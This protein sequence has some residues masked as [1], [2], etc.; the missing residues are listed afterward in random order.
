LYLAACGKKSAK[1]QRPI[2]P[3]A[4]RS[5]L[6]KKPRML[7]LALDTACYVAYDLAHC[8]LYKV[9]KGGVLMEGAPYT[10]K[11]N[12]EP[13]TWGTSYFSDSLKKFKWVAELNGKKDSSQIVSKGYVL[14]ITRSTLNMH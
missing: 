8:T 3:W 7:T 5:V 14:K 1:I 6:D 13:T 9:W 12:V 11:K 2:D 4:F 10:N